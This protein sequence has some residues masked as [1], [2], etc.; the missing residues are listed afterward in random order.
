MTTIEEASARIGGAAP[1][2]QA[3]RRAAIAGGALAALG[4]T[5]LLMTPRRRMDVLGRAKLG[6]VMP[7]AV[8]PWR[9]T[10]GDGVI[11]PDADTDPGEYYDQMATRDFAGQDL[12]AVMLLTAYGA[13]QRGLIRVHR[14]ETCYES[15][16]FVLQHER[17]TSIPLAGAAAIPAH[18]FIANRADRREQVLYWIRMGDSLTL[19][20]R[21]QKLAMLERGLQGVIPDGILVRMSTLDPDAGRGMRA[22]QL[23]ARTLVATAT[24][25]LH[26]LLVGNAIAATTAGRK[27]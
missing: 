19:N 17:D 11:V 22:L 27:A 4:A 5:A 26:Q 8:G 7:H 3:S 23:F 24:P 1:A 15:A 21:R 20:S 10:S 2:P 6:D 16:G 9:E 14:P 13:A 25:K 18:T 12:P